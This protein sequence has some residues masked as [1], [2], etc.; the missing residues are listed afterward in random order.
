MKRRVQVI[1]EDQDRSLENGDQ[2][3]M[4]TVSKKGN[5]Q[6]Y[7]EMGKVEVEVRMRTRTRQD[8]DEDRTR[9][10]QDKDE[11]KARMRTRQDNR[12]IGR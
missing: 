10:R 4:N 12:V 8:E 11:D 1:H 3:G 6:G 5:T 9:T 7:M 2:R